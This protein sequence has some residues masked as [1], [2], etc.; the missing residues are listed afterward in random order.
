MPPEDR[1][2]PVQRHDPRREPAVDQT[3]TTQPNM[4]QSD[5]LNLRFDRLFREMEQD[6]ELDRNFRKEVT[7][8]LSSHD[9]KITSLANEIAA[10][11]EHVKR[12]S[13]RM[14]RYV[15]D[16]EQLAKDVASMR[17]HIS[18]TNEEVIRQ[19]DHDHEHEA[20]VAEEI[21]LQQARH[22]QLE[23]NVASIRHTVE[24]LRGESI[25]LRENLLKT[26]EQQQKLALSQVQTVE[27]TR[28]VQEET[29]KQTPKLDDALSGI[30]ELV[31]AIAA[32]GKKLSGKWK[33]ILAI[34]TPIAALLGSFLG[35]CAEG[36]ELHRQ[37]MQ[38]PA[39]QAPP[40][41]TPPVLGSS[42]R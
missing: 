21:V 37:R 2:T 29:E 22:T 11:R 23:K 38:T 42:S 4:P 19:S 6:R 18:T 1:S 25:E 27:A 8:N 35:S 28:A 15:T 14:A 9:A 33:T 16:T 13:T 3:A 34:V 36:Y 39:Y 24:D 41:P 10:T 26:R 7:Q 31:G 5:V 30:S 17:G 12:Q 40:T 20:R 32:G